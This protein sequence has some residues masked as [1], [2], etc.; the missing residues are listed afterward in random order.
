[1]SPKSEFALVH[2][3]GTNEEPGSLPA[4]LA[5]LQ[6]TPGRQHCMPLSSTV[7]ECICSPVC[8]SAL[9]TS[10]CHEPL[11]R[12][13]RFYQGALAPR[14]ACLASTLLDLSGLCCCV[15]WWVPA[16]PARLLFYNRP[17]YTI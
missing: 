11:E 1:M 3:R 12:S 15:E 14:K 7:Q 13:T 8:K 10:R 17:R 5:T 16:A 2:R 6:M 9:A 4:Q